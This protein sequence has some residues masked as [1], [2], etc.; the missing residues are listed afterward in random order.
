MK[1]FEKER[2]QSK[3]GKENSRGHL[4]STVKMK[5]GLVESDIE[6]SESVVQ[7]HRLPVSCLS[8]ADLNWSLSGLLIA[9]QTI[10]IETFVRVHLLATIEK[11]SRSEEETIEVGEKAV[12]VMKNIAIL[13][14]AIAV[15][16]VSQREKVRRT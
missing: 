6:K 15:N 7:C 5:T 16:S 14:E 1:T 10:I 8:S 9:R 2:K 12:K 11:H 4:V 3:A 13:E